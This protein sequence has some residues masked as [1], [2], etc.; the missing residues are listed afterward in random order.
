[1]TPDSDNECDI[2]VIDDDRDFADSLVQLLRLEGYSAAAAYSGDEALAFVERATVSVALVDIILGHADGVGLIPEL[3]KRCPAIVNVIMTAYASVE[4]AIEALKQG[5]YDYLCKP[6]YT[7]DL[8]STLSRC[9]ERH[10]LARE[11]EQAEAA[12]RL[13]NSELQHLNARLAGILSSLRKLSRCS[14]PAA[15]HELLL[16]LVLDDLGADEGVLYAR[17]NHHLDMKAHRGEGYESEIPLSPPPAPLF[18]DALACRRPALSADASKLAGVVA[19]LPGRE[20]AQF[21]AFPLLDNDDA[22]LGVVLAHR[23]GG[24]AFTAQDIELARI[25]TS[26]GAEVLVAVQAKER[27]A[28]SEQRLR[29]VV[30]HSPSAIS[31]KDPRGEYLL[32]NTRFDEWFEGVEDGES[33]VS[34]DVPS[35]AA[36]MQRGETVTHEVETSGP[37]GTKQWL[38]ITKF[39]VPD[40]EGGPLG[41]GNITTDVT[42]RRR[43]QERLGQAQKMEA[44]GQLTGGVAHDFNNLLAVILGNLRLLQ[45]DAGEGTEFRELLDE[46]IDATRSGVDLT[47][48]LL[49]F[50]RAQ[51]LRP[52]VTD[53]RELVLGMSRLLERTLGSRIAIELDLAQDLWPTRIDRSQLEASLLNL[54][55]NARDAMPEGGTLRIEAGNAIID[56]AD[57]SRHHDAKAGAHVLLSVTDTG[58]GMPPHVLDGAVQP[59]FTTK[60]AGQGSGL[61]LSMVYGFVTQSG[62][63]LE[64][65]SRPGRGTTARL[66]FPKA[67]EEKTSAARQVASADKISAAGR[68]V[69]VVEDQAGVRRL[70]HRLLTRL[71]HRVLEAPDGQMAMDIL[72]ECDD[73]DVLFTDI[74]LPGRISGTALGHAAVRMRPGLQV[75]YTTGYAAEN[76]VDTF[77]GAA[78]HILYKPVQIEELSRVIGAGSARG[79][80]APDGSAEP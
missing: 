1:M 77:D 79:G 56:W 44:L 41:V 47:G 2:L 40:G 80:E 42:E 70:T 14:K 51:T 55:I 39:P 78:A 36:V 13:R 18:G 28:A 68:R 69:L 23:P 46:A 52:Q 66:Y 6:F 61:G 53:I 58:V 67:S 20:N 38:L 32:T 63:H 11:R 9:F 75:V 30:E 22:P 7:D 29:K 57:R 24:P 27:L 31:L 45:E 48:R 19:G 15:L 3:R 34:P 49:A 4:T 35:D 65:D 26:F 60:E 74:V 12:V 76:L 62:G 25:L 16:N 59:F 64:L 33:D 37:E 17:R 73:I 5:A 50:G 43:A 8:L 72:R 71:G 10:R 54:A 21:L